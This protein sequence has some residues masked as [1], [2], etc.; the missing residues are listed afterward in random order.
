MDPET[1]VQWELVNMPVGLEWSGR[2][3]YAAAMYFHK[4]GEMDT[5]TLEVYRY[6]ARL[7]AEDPVA[8]L[9]RY[10]IGDD[11]VARIEAERRKAS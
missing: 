7:D 1:T 4:R 5:A 10:R 3:R 6:L 11:W 8:A 9:K 2:A